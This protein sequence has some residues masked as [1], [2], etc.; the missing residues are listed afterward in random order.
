MTYHE[1][2]PRS[3]SLPEAVDL[4]GDWWQERRPGGRPAFLVD[5][6]GSDG[7]SVLREV[8]RRV[9]GSVFVDAHGRTAEEVHR[10]VLLALGVD[11][12]PGQR[13]RWRSS[14]RQVPEAR[15]VLIANAHRAGR[16]RLAH[17]PDRLISRTVAG[18]NSGNVAVVAHTSPRDLPNRS[19]VVL[20]LPENAASERLESPLLQALALAEPREVPLRVW[21][22]LA[23]ALTGGTVSETVLA[24]LAQDHSDLIQSGPDGISFVDEGIAERLR[25]EAEPDEITRVNQHLVDWLRRVSREFRHPEGWAAHGPEGRYAATGLAA[26]AVQANAL[27]ELLRH[28]ELLANIPPIALMDA[29]CCAFGGRV[30]G[31]SAAADGIHLWSYGMVPSGQSDWAALMHL[32]ATARKDTAF[33]V[34]VAGSGVQLPWTTK[35]TRWRPPGGYHV[36]YTKAMPL[37]ALAEVRWQDRAAVAGL[38]ERTQPDAAIWDAET[39]ALLAGP[40][41]GDG[42]PE[43]HRGA[44]SWPPLP[45]GT[46]SSNDAAGRPGPLTF[47]DLH[48]GVPAGRGPHPS[49]LES[50]PLRVGDLV[51]LGGS[52]GLFAIE[53]EPGEEFSGFGSDNGRP[54][55]GPYAMVGPTAPLDAPPPGPK[56]LIELYGDEEIFELEEEEIPEGLTDEAARRTLLEFGLPDLREGGMGLYPYGDHRFEVMDEVFWPDD[57]PPA[58]ETGPFFQIG[59]WMGG[60]LVVDGPTGH[61]LRIP[62]EPDEDHLAALPA[63]CSV[64]GFLTMVGLWVTGLRTKQTVHNDLEAVLLPQ[65]V[66]IAQSAV[67][68]TGAEAP[69]WS[70]VF[71][72]E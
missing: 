72:N 25:R 9:A 64:E 59:F 31:N 22:E 3:S 43:G 61:V 49:L 29:A 52:G 69:A 70:Y 46:E 55:S 23:V 14:L 54:L 5:P 45:A 44:L 34:G 8:H 6:S 10:E 67:D 17:E 37:T 51:V 40:W 62:T 24:Q 2:A 4:I 56:D 32:M 15:L 68:S 16:T 53:P 60:E 7:A 39:G 42:I 18:L 11:L 28:G 38:C 21:A 58:D 71:H 12:G 20:R 48:N 36:S 26:H 27:E 19:I 65:Y 41:Q 35:W 13:S 33:A 63:A 66:A 57:V 50:P 30:P 47:Q 1:D